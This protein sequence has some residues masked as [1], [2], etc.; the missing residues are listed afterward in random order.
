MKFNEKLIELRKSTDPESKCVVY[1]YI[2][3]QNDCENHLHMMCSRCGR[4][5]HLG[6]DFMSKVSEHIFTHH[7]FT[8][9]NS[10]T[11]I[12]GICGKCADERRGV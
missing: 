3:K 2:D 11:E 7:D 5:F 10:R 6:C 9:D 1:Q 8:V 4:I 12:I